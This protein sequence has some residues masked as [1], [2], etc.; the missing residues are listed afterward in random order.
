MLF[1]SNSIFVI[2]KEGVIK[3]KEIPADLEDDFKIEDFSILLNETV[4]FKPKGHT[5]ENWMGV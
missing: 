2:D 4:N 3:Y 1:R 5:H